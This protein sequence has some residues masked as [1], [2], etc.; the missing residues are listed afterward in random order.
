MRALDEQQLMPTATATVMQA[1]APE[2]QRAP[3]L[4]WVVL[5][6]FMLFLMERFIAGRRSKV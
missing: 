6:A 1:A 5:A 4:K 3:L 2:A